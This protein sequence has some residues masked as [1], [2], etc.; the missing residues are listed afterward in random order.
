MK[1]KQERVFAMVSTITTP[2]VELARSPLTIVCFQCDHPL[3]RYPAHTI[4]VSDIAKK[5]YPK[6]KPGHKADYDLFERTNVLQCS[7]GLV[8]RLVA[9]NRVNRLLGVIKRTIIPSDLRTEHTLAQAVWPRCSLRSPPLAAV[10][11]DGSVWTTKGEKDTTSRELMALHEW[12][13]AITVGS[14]NAGPA[15][16]SGSQWMISQ[17]VEEKSRNTPKSQ[18]YLRLSL[19]C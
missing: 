14:K 3:A 5:L 18:A 12:N 9:Q 7:Q 17:S 6:G 8:D 2:S 1:G 13:A 16:H 10:A 19:G 4:K 11:S 15:R